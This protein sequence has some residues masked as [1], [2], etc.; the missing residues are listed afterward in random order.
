M[1]SFLPLRSSFTRYRP[2]LRSCLVTPAGGRNLTL[3]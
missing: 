1:L 2:S 3:P